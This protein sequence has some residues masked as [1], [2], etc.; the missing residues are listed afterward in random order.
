VL[1]SGQARAV[2]RVTPLSIEE[3]CS[4]H[5]W[6]DSTDHCCG[7]GPI[8]SLPDCNRKLIFCRKSVEVLGL[9][10]FSFFCLVKFLCWGT[11]QVLMDR[12]ILCYNATSCVEAR[13]KLSVNGVPSVWPGVRSVGLDG[14][15]NGLRPFSVEPAWPMFLVGGT[16]QVL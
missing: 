4:P 15:R 7:K 3:R 11:A 8:Y 5:D 9:G 1:D 10:F 6:R 2:T 12:S 16:A 14:Q 13:R